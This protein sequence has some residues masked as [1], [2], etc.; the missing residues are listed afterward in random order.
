MIENFEE[1][2]AKLL[3]GVRKES[4]AMLLSAEDRGGYLCRSQDIAMSK[5]DI[6]CA[7]DGFI[8][9]YCL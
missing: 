3:S 9:Q 1:R 4:C 2:Y 6:I 5:N 7:E 8:V